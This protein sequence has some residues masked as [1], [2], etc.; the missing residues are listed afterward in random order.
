MRQ[1]TWTTTTHVRLKRVPYARSRVERELITFRTVAGLA[2]MLDF[3]L[4][5]IEGAIRIDD[6]RRCGT[7]CIRPRSETIYVRNV[8]GILRYTEMGKAASS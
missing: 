6:S 5:A 8:D 3:D 4:W 2:V 1:M 7:A